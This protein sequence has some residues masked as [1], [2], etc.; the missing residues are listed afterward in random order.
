MV[1]TIP[2]IGSEGIAIQLVYYIT[3]SAVNQISFSTSD[4]VS[5]PIQDHGTSDTTF[6]ITPNTMHV[7]GEVA[8][9]TITLA[10]NDGTRSYEYIFKFDSGAT[11]TV[12][13]LPSDLK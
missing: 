2:S 10:S 9:L 7:W 5:Y 11:A 3:S 6:A 1:Y 12:L 8:S 4:Y 13:S